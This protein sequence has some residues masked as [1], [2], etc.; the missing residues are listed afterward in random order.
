MSRRRNTGR[1]QG[2][3]RIAVATLIFAGIGAYAHAQKHPSFS[4]PKTGIVLAG[5][6]LAKCQKE[7]VNVGGTRLGCGGYT[8]SQ[9]GSTK[10]M[11][12][13]GNRD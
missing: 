10:I 7:T 4:E 6:K 5:E 13:S 9:S 12:L 8:V 3:L 2:F 11:F 1:L